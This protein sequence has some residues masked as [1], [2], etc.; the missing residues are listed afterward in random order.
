MVASIAAWLWDVVE[1][2]GGAFAVEYRL[3]DLAGRAKVLKDLLAATLGICALRH[4]LIIMLLEKL[5]PD[6]YGSRC[7]LL[8]F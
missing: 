1:A 7:S 5:R 4:P 3:A 6:V 8:K 2:I